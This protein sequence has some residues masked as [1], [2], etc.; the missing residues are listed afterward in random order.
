MGIQIFYL[1]PCQVLSLSQ[2]SDTAGVGAKV[3][4]E[5]SWLDCLP[6]R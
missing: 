5:A 6:E 3:F 4:W 2:G 1:P